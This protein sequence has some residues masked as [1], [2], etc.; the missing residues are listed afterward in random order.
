[1]IMN[2]KGK[3]GLLLLCGATVLLFGMMIAEFTFPGYSVSQ[4][5]ISDLAVGPMASSLVFTVAVILF[6]FSAL[7]GAVLLRQKSRKSLLWLFLS[8]SAIG[9][10]GVGVINENF[11]PAVHAI[12]ALMAFLFGNLAAIYSYKMV[13]PP[14]SYLFACLGIVGLLALVLLASGIF[15]GLGVGGME[16]MIFYPAMFWTLGFGVYLLAEE[17]AVGTG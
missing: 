2:D 8:L 3:G 4:N 1:M 7:V 9:A 16:R 10:I 14:L 11:I 5:Y 15:L 12:F 13:R 6:G 17:N